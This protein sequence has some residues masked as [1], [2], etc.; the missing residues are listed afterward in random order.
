MKI[1]IDCYGADYSPDELV[2]GAITSVNLID[3][4]EIILT[5]NKE[6]IQKVILD[7]VKAAHQTLDV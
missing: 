1:V 2:K 3:D 5:G 6:E 7:T 4:V